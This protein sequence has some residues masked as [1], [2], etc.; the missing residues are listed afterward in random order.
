MII[1]LGIFLLLG[2]STVAMA[3]PTIDGDLSDWGLSKLATNSWKFNDTWLPDPAT[4]TIANAVDFIIEDNH[5]PRWGAPDGVHI[6]GR[7]SSYMPYLEP[8][9][10]HADGNWYA[11]PVGGEYFD[12]EALYLYQDATDIYLAVVTSGDPSQGGGLRPGDLALNLDND[13]STGEFGYEYGVFIS[14][15][16]HYPQGTILYHPHWEGTGAIIPPNTDIIVP[17]DFADTAVV[18]YADISYSNSWMTTIDN[19]YEPLPNW[20]IEMK[21]PK[22]DVGVMG[23]INMGNLRYADNC[24]NDHIFIPEFPTFA[25]LIGMIFGLA[26]TVYFIKSKK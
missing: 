24:L 25:L 19:N 18:G 22:S 9:V 13:L 4:S 15:L 14:S 21:I 11:E 2:I 5:D 26:G 12:I 1:I 17:P 23:N 8:K 6:R 7:T 16:G 3:A 20:V 10:Q